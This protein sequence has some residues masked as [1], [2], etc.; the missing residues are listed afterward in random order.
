MKKITFASI[1]SLCMVPILFWSTES[2]AI[3]SW[4]RKYEVSCF[5]CHSGMPQRNAIGEA[6]K[7]NGYRMPAGVETA[8]TRQQQIKIGTEEWK[9]TLG[10]PQ[11]SSFPQFDPLSVVLTGNMINYKAATYTSAGVESAPKELNYNAPSTVA[12]FF[13]GSVGDHLT[14]FGEVNGFGSGSVETDKDGNTVTASLDTPVMANVR[15]VWEFSPGFDLAL[16][17]NFSNASWNGVS[18]GGVVNVSGILPAPG[19]YAEL[20]YTRGETGG[21]SI[22]AGTSMAAKSN[23]PIVNSENKI[24]DILYLRGKYKIF[25]AGLLSGANGEF[26]NPYTG[27][28]NQITLGAGLSYTANKGAVKNPITGVTPVTGFTANYLGETLVYGG[29]IQGVYNDF[30]AG[31][32]VSRDRD[33]QLNNFKAEIGHYL[34]TWLYAKAA[35]SD[36]AN[37]SKIA[38]PYDVHQPSIIGSISA[39]L[40]SAV[41]LTGTYTHFTKERVASGITNQ[42]SFILAVRAGF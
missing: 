6:F 19:T 42:D 12:L 4:A 39:W 26:G 27:L 10:A 30:L 36:V 32:A 31:L 9:K 7:N 24:D 2:Q 28:D 29:D 34:Y 41:S 16:G 37:G 18:V 13:G 11:N 5:L 8:F 14:I 40:S 20:N 3:P 22:T 1:I 35:Y 23:T 17:N 15:A 21:Y 25:G 38:V 33:L